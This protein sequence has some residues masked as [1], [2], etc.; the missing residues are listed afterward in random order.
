MTF[1]SGVPGTASFRLQHFPKQGSEL[2]YIIIR[3]RF[4]DPACVE[5]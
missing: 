2:D 1:N 4:D 3:M 5:L